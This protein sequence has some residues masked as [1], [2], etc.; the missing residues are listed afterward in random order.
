MT[1]RAKLTATLATAA[2]TTVL[3]GCGVQRTISIAPVQPVSWAKPL[4][5]QT[6]IAYSAARTTGRLKV[7]LVTDVNGLQDNGY[8]HLAELGLLKAQSILNVQADVTQ[9]SS[10]TDYV[11]NLTAYAT[12]GYN[13]VIG[14]GYLMDGA[15]KQVSKAYPNIKFVILDDPLANRP[16][17]TAVMFH[18]EQAGF[19]AGALAGLMEQSPNIKGMNPENTVGIVGGEPIAQ[20]KAY[21][22]GFTQGVKKTDPS[23]SIDLKYAGSFTSIAAGRQLASTE[24]AD[25]ADIILQIAGKVGVGV[26]QACH[27]NHVY[28][29]GV[30]TNQRNLDPTTVITSAIKGIDSATYDVVRQIQENTLK[31]G[32]ET[33]G[34]ADGGVRLT[35]P[36][37][38]VPR[39][40]VS[41]V[42]A[43]AA[44]IQSGTIQVNPTLTQ[45]QKK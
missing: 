37:P 27:A 34:V 43:L 20:V 7:G 18:T 29:M 23:V 21:V 31:P 12:K 40:L 38:L 13:L 25:G 45:P 10:S 44:Q 5:K 2:I 16:N 19:L 33:F 26:F 32:I 17:V 1:Q 35:T 39:R 4:S 14:V 3:A 41:Q 22:A 8:N 9:S 24:I 28:A 30:D 11:Q 36:L 6:T 15:M 42:A